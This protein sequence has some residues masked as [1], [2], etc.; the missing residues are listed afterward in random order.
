MPRGKKSFELAQKLVRLGANEIKN[1][2]VNRLTIVYL[3]D[4]VLHAKIQ[5]K[6]TKCKVFYGSFLETRKKKDKAFYPLV[7]RAI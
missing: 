7:I 3:F 5:N 1:F 4:V 2:G 6:K